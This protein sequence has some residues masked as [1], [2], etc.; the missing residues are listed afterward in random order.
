MPLLLVLSVVITTHNQSQGDCVWNERR[1][2]Y[3]GEERCVRSFSYFPHDHQGRPR[4]ITRTRRRPCYPRLMK[5]FAVSPVMRR[6]TLQKCEWV[7]KPTWKA[8]S[9]IVMSVVCI[10]T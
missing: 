9:A 3:N 1:T 4:I 2:E 6:Y 5:R 7:L 8:I 10:S